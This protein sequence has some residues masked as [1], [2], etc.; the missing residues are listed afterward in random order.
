MPLQN[1][2]SYNGSIPDS[3]SGGCSSNLYIPTK[4]GSRLVGNGICLPN[5][6][7]VGSNLTYRTKF[8]PVMELV[9][10]LDSKSKFSRFES[11]LGYKTNWRATQIGEEDGLENR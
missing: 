8:A 4:C 9:Y 3:D 10:I 5:R 1:G 11:W 7:N 6:N 2:I